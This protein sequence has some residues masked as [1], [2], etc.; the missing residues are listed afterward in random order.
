MHF[1][2]IPQA[3]V[4]LRRIHVGTQPLDSRSGSGNRCDR[5]LFIGLGSF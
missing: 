4:G 1:R 5:Q 3:V 2:F